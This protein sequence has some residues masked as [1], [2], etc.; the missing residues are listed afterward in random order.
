M[1]KKYVYISM[2]VL[3]CFLFSHPVWSARKARVRA[4]VNYTKQEDHWKR[5]DCKIYYIQGR[6]RINIADEMV[7]LFAGTDSLIPL[8]N[9]LTNMDGEVE[10][11]IP[12][13]FKLPDDDNG[14]TQ[15]TVQYYGNDSFSSIERDIEVQD[16]AFN[17][18]PF[19]KDSVKY[20]KVSARSVTPDSL[21]V[22][23]GI[24]VQLLVDRMFMPLPLESA[25]L[26][27]E[28]TIFKIPGGIP[29]DP[30]GNLK[31][32]AKVEFHDLYQNVIQSKV[33]NWG[34]PTRHEI[35][36]SYRAL[37]TQ[38]APRWMI[39]TL[40]ILL[41]GVWSHYIYVIIQLFFIKKEIKG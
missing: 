23:S 18:E 12:P 38:I 34:I 17:I 20:V 8:G 15:F 4:S 37:W 11:L 5:I 7:Y 24:Q 21:Y 36:Q 22:V 10:F 2:L 41:L 13:K 19:I 30:E 1:N 29:G 9:N 16:L 40:T 27:E 31:L 6:S 26:Q 25:E 33:V 32:L 39:I 35:P 14:I 3:S 28:G